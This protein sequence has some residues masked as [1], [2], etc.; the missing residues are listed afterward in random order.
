MCQGSTVKMV[1]GAFARLYLR[2]ELL[3]FS[4]AIRIQLD[5]DVFKGAMPVFLF[6][7]VRVNVYTFRSISN[8]ISHENTANRVLET[9]Y[10]I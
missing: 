3:H 6:F 10:F 5:K 4:K 2:S 9:G 7:H 1:F 8:F